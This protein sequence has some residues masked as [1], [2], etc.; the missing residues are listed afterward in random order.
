MSYTPAGAGAAPETDPTTYYTNYGDGAG[1]GG[2]SVNIGKDAGKGATATGNVAIGR[3]AFGIGPM[4]GTYSLAVGYEAGKIVDGGSNAIYIGASAG[5]CAA[6]AASSSGGVFIGGH[7][8]FLDSGQTNNCVAIGYGAQLQGHYT[9]AF[10]KGAAAKAAGALAIGTDSSGN[11]AQATASNDFVLGTASHKVKVPGTLTV[12]GVT[13]V[14]TPT[15]G[16]NA[17]TKAYVD[18]AM[19][20]G[21][22]VAWGGASAPTGWQLCNGTLLSRTVH[23]DLFDVIGV[24]YG[25]GDGVTTFA[26]PNLQGKV[27]VS[28]G[29]G[30]SLNGSGG[31]STHTLTPA[32]MPAHSHQY[33]ADDRQMAAML[34]YGSND[35][36]QVGGDKVWMWI[37]S[38]TTDTGGSQPHNNMPPYAVLNYIIKL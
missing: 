20:T 36:S 18:Q 29:G 23:K 7:T 4:V 22:I 24:Q 10:G 6:G 12:T 14:P 17:A 38:R 35:I 1:T 21:A 32:E 25:I 8:E 31:A 2:S 15:T 28:S 33:T 13:T 16:T 26:A 27:I 11:G 30:F 19:P 5:K 9:N 37:G 3:N 34:G